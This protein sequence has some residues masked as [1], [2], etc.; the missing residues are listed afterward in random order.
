MHS[1]ILVYLHFNLLLENVFLQVFHG[2][3]IHLKDN[4]LSSVNS[5]VI[6]HLVRAANGKPVDLKVN[7]MQINNLYVNVNI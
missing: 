7:V 5:H 3:I 4:V 6:S 2:M 1:A